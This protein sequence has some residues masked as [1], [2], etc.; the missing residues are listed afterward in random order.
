MNVEMYTIPS[1][2]EFVAHFRQI[3]AEN[4]MPSTVDVERE[5]N[6]SFDKYDGE[7]HWRTS[8]GE[9]IKFWPSICKRCVESAMQRSRMDYSAPKRTLV[10]ADCCF[11]PIEQCTCVSLC[12]KDKSLVFPRD[13]AKATAAI[14][15]DEMAAF[16][17]LSRSRRMH[18]SKVA[19]YADEHF[20]NSHCTDIGTGF[21]ERDSSDR[22]V[23]KAEEYFNR[24]ALWIEFASIVNV[25]WCHLGQQICDAYSDW[26]RRNGRAMLCSTYADAW[27][28]MRAQQ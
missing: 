19:D 24:M 21:I 5:A 7:H 15:D 13:M 9:R 1:R 18:E 25:N 22:Y 3:A 27:E 16:T 8:A 11:R 20:I 17:I 23:E 12:F 14:A 10:M 4:H 26:C 28:M 2:E 6:R